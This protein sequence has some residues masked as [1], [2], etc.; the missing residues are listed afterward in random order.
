MKI[1]ERNTTMKKK[2]RNHI[3][4][5]CQDQ[6]WKIYFDGT[7]EQCYNKICFVEQKTFA[8][9]ILPLMKWYNAKI[10]NTKRPWLYFIN[11]HMKQVNTFN[12]INLR[13]TSTNQCRSCYV[14]LCTNAAMKQK[15][16]NLEF[17]T[18]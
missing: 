9:L 1:A 4:N 18:L 3:W 11:L 8:A 17:K 15:L 7:I 2:I 14:I 6:C 10:T 12:E 16:P 5:D 13:Q